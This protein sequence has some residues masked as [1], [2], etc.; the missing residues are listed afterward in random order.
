MSRASQSIPFYVDIGKNALLY[1]RLNSQPI[2]CLPLYFMIHFIVLLVFIFTL[3]NGQACDFTNGNYILITDQVAVDSASSACQNVAATFVSVPTNAVQFNAVA[4]LL[5]VC[6]VTLGQ[7]VYVNNGAPCAGAQIISA[8]PAATQLQIDIFDAGCDTT[9]PVLCAIATTVQTSITSTIIITITLPTE[10]ITSAPTELTT[11][12]TTVTVA[13]TTISTLLL[14]T[15]LFR[16]TKSTS[17]T[18]T[19]PEDTF[20]VSQTTSTST[21]VTSDTL[22]RTVSETATVSFTETV[23]VPVVITI[24]N[25]ETEKS[26]VCPA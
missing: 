25:T 8:P 20:S 15:S 23:I 5:A 13:A 17:S 14:S 18:I 21:I 6:G 26:T 9:R 1:E 10:T 24:T 3:A 2:L 12:S 7:Q 22:S 4:D 11:E 16:S 19:I